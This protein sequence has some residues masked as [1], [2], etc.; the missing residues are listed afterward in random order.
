[1]FDQEIY[2]KIPRDIPLSLLNGY[3]TSYS[4]LLI[5]ESTDPNKEGDFLINIFAN[6]TLS[7]KPLGKRVETP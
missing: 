5:V 3:S 6:K 7:D 4:I 1:M 2:E